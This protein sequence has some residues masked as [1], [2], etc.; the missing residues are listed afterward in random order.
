[1]FASYPQAGMFG[2]L[3]EAL[4]SYLRELGTAASPA[5]EGRITEGATPTRSPASPA[6]SDRDE[7]QAGSHS[8][9]PIVSG[10]TT[11]EE[12]AKA[13]DYANYTVKKG[14]TLWSIAKRYN[15]TWQAICDVNQTENPDRITSDSSS[16]FRYSSKTALRHFKW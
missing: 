7:A 12:P 3:D 15:T 1:M 14:D 11:Q 5:V 6:P 4:T 10:G 9:R 8:A 2:A 16:K 13:A